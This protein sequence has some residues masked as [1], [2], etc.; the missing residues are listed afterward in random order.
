MTNS[1]PYTKAAMVELTTYKRIRGTG[2]V[3]TV[4]RAV[5]AVGF[6]DGEAW[7]LFYAGP[8]GAIYETRHTD[9]SR[10]W[11][12]RALSLTA[13]PMTLDTAAIRFSNFRDATDADRSE[14]FGD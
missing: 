2:A 9:P 1:N 11:V 4:T 10:V 5:T 12:C 3:T 14:V 7:V 8:R 6:Q 13:R